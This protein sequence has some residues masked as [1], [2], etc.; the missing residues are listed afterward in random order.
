[1]QGTAHDIAEG[2]P[3]VAETASR[4]VEQLASG[5]EKELPKVCACP[6]ACNSPHEGLPM[7]F[8]G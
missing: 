1:M 4:Q 6:S 8:D 7:L 5:L 3:E 2:V